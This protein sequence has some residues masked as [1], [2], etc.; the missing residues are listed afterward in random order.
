MVKRMGKSKLER[1]NSILKEMGSCVV[2]YSGGVDS[3]FLLKV[4]RDALGD[5]VASATAISAT[6]PDDEYL[7]ARRMAKYLGARHI[8]VR[9]RELE[10]EGFSD[11]STQRCYYCKKELYMHLAQIAKRERLSWVV[12]GSNLDDENDFRPGRAA[13]KEMGVRSPLME[14][15]LTKS[16][17]RRLS[18]QMGLSTWDK[19]SLAC[20]ASR[21]AYGDKISEAKLKMVDCGEK[22]LK[23]FGIKQVRLRHHGDIARIEVWGKDMRK[24]LNKDFREKIIS[25]LKRLGYRYV[26]LDLEGYRTGSMNL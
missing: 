11:N 4:A 21:F 7:Q 10:I 5:K 24:F 9:T 3:T 23:S 15:K 6:Y 1:L 18:K 13:A 17:I 19:P 16:D 8:I 22:F 26:T 20:L 2:A 25:K 12:D 14:A